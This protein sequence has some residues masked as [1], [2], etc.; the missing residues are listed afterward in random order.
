[1]QATRI[2]VVAV[3]LGTVSACLPIPHRG[4]ASPLLR[5]Q[6]FDART[7][8]PVKDAKIL[9]LTNRGEV[10]A[11]ERSNDQGRFEL[12][13]VQEWRYFV[14]LIGDSVLSGDVKVSHPDYREVTKAYFLS[15]ADLYR[16]GGPRQ[17][18]GSIQLE[19]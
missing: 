4:D 13:P 17:D 1:M 10:L 19:K 7:Q 8:L 5:G 15:G 16:A 11:E 6:V 18:L 14:F 2:V 12:R 9:L 3:V